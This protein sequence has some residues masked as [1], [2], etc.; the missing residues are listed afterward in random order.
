[1]CSNRVLFKQ[2]LKS[3]AIQYCQIDSCRLGSINE[4]LAVYFMA[5]KFNGTNSI[6]LQIN[7]YQ[8]FNVAAIDKTENV[9]LPIF[10]NSMIATCNRLQILYRENP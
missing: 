2:L 8:V 5:K 9:E 4:I 6:L 3:G 7:I 10:F 1:M